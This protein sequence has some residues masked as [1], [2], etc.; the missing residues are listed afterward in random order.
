[1]V[2][3]VVPAGATESVALG[4][5]GPDKGKS[6]PLTIPIPVPRTIEIVSESAN[7]V[8]LLMELY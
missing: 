5:S 8:E 3:K 4:S 6:G 2:S 1:M 7:F